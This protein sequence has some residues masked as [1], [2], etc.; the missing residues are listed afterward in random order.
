[1]DRSTFFADL[2]RS[3]L[4]SERAIEEAAAGVPEG[5]PARAIA[6]H[7]VESGLLTRY[8]A[9]RVLAGKPSRLVLGQYRILDKVGS[10]GTGRVYKALHTSMDRVVAIKVIRPDLLKDSSILNS[11]RREVRAVSKLHHPNIVAAY[12][13]NEIRG[14]NFLVMEYVEGMNLHQL[15][16]AHGPLPVALACEVMRQAAQA[17]QYAH[18]RGIVHRDVKPSNLI[19]AELSEA[20]LREPVAGTP[21]PAAPVVKVLDFGLARLHGGADASGPDT[22]TAPDGGVFGTVDYI[23]PEQADNIHAA[24]VRSDLYSLGCTF[25]HVL[26]GAVP[27]PARTAM[28]KL[29]KQL[30]TEP[31]PLESVRPEIPA[32]V[33]A[34]V[35]RLMAKDR[36]ERFQTPAELIRELA[37]WCDPRAG[38]AEAPSPDSGPGVTALGAAHETAETLF[39]GSDAVTYEPAVGPP[40]LPGTRPRLDAE[41]LEKWRQWTALIRMSLSQRG[42]RRWINVKEFQALQ[43]DLANACRAQARRTG[44]NLRKLFEAMEGL[45]RPWITPESLMRTDAEIHHSLLVHC[46]QAEKDLERWAGRPPERAEEVQAPGGLF[47]LFKRRRERPESEEEES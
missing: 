46:E 35:R 24:D 22:V 44:G 36:A 13:A 5:T 9:G 12:D 31:Q 16:K 10:G 23:S 15:V 25:Y 34:I 32:P 18:E 17:L 41:F 33:A 26:A 4:L 38:Q 39:A 37:P 1:M 19:V 20:W 7:L 27:F 14:V 47:A 6:R 45:V 21:S 28:E 29:L 11:F 43:K 8:Q 40:P 3:Q 2:R 42:S 30:T